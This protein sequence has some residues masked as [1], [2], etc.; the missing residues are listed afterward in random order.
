M[1]PCCCSMQA[2]IPVLKPVNLYCNEA[3][4][5]TLGAAEG[6]NC[7]VF[8]EPFSEICGNSEK[9]SLHFESAEVATCFV[10]PEHV[11]YDKCD[12][13]LTSVCVLCVS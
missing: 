5:K 6:T 8:K 2:V 7:F 9:K 12:I 1:L 13:D 3:L 4:M 11:T 10:Y